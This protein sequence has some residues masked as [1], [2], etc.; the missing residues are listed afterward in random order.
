MACLTGLPKLFLDC[1]PFQMEFF[2]I[3]VHQLTRYRLTCS[4]SV[5]L[6]GDLLLGWEH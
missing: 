2:Y 1:K 3:I 6:T 4:P 5:H